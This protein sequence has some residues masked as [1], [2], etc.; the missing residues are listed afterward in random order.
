MNYL[1]LGGSSYLGSSFQKYLS[2][3]NISSISLST[4]NS[5]NYSEKKIAQVLSKYSPKRIVDFK[6]PIVSSDD[7]LFKDIV[8]NEFFSAQLK[9]INTLN[10]LEYDFNNIYVISSENINRSKTKYTTYKKKQEKIYKEKLDRKD[11]LRIIRLHSV[12]GPGDLSRY[13]IIPNFFRQVFDSKEVI[14]NIN[15]NKLGY[16]NYIDETNKYIFDVTEGIDTKR[17]FYKCTY[18]LLI[19]TLSSILINE[20]EF[21]HK[22]LWNSKPLINKREIENKEFYNYLVETTNWYFKNTLN[23]K[24]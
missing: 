5:K 12:F 6:F 1:I 16:F 19:Q 3:K 18:N 13:R 4:K 11:K 8:E 9:L 2:N 17:K 15:S 23:K 14:F 7:N 20:F 10:S 22:V 24:G 21:K